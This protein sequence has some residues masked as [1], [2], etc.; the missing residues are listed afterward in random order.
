[1]ESADPLTKLAWDKAQEFL[2][3]SPTVVNISQGL[4]LES[5]QLDSLF[6]LA[7]TIEA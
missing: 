2:R 4:N 3:N 7:A 1:M 6:T 5:D